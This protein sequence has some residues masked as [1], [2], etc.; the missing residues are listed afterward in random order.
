MHYNINNYS[1]IKKGFEEYGYSL[2]DDK[3]VNNKTYMRVICPFGHVWDVKW[4]NFISG[5]RCPHCN[6]MNK[7]IKAIIEFDE[8]LQLNGYTLLD[9]NNFKTK[10]SK[11]LIKCPKGHIIRMSYDKFRSGNR[12]KY[13]NISKGERKIIQ[14]LSTN[15]IGFI[16]QYKFKDCKNMFELPFDFYIPSLN[17]CIEYDGE[18][19]YKIGKFNN[20]LL[21]LMNLKRRD[22]IKNQYCKEN[23]IKLI[24]I[25]YYEYD[26][27]EKILKRELNLK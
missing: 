2:I 3:Y 1:D 12:C 13:C 23:N 27:I 4:T 25:P 5:N 16:H 15:H 24:R 17:L 21:D 8:L 26:N 6:K 18:Q 11:V 22:N 10:K 9:W 14:C 19:H 20:T 7:R